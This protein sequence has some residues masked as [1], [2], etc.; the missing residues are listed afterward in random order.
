LR[1]ENDMDWYEEMGV[2]RVI[3]AAFCLTVLGGSTLS[4]E[5]LDAYGEANKYF[6]EMRDLCIKAGK[7]IAGITGAE[8]AYITTGAFAGLVLSAAACMAGKDPDKMSKLPNTAGM[9]NEIIIQR[10]MRIVFDRSMEIPGGNFVEVEPTLA[11]LEA[12]ITEKT[13]AIHYLALMGSPRKSIPLEEV[14][15]LGHKHGVPIIVDAAGQTY[16]PDRLKTFVRMGADL[17]CYSGKYFSGPNSTGFVCGKKDLVE[18]IAENSFIGP[19]VG[20]IGRAS[21][22]DRQ[23][24]VALVVALQRWMEMDHEKVRL[25]PAREK[26]TRLIEALKDIPNIKMMPKE[27]LHNIG[28]QITL[29]KYTPEETSN[30]VK[31]LE[32]GDPSIVIR[33]VSK[34]NL[35]INTLFLVDGDDRFLADRLKSLIVTRSA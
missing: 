34:N 25:H 14:V 4:K 1:E 32:E 30:L 19:G 31:E 18:A 11:D 16:P 12:A 35:L 8:A 28:L 7:I 26:R 5:M 22:L 23:E 2:R 9:K 21:K 20:W 3:N 27:S 10:T 6:V 13:A 24:I 29:E 33:S 17:V 15:D